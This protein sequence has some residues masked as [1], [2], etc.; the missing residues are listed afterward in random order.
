M[1]RSEAIKYKEEFKGQ[2]ELL[3]LL[4]VKNTKK[5]RNEGNS[6]TNKKS[7]Y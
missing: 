5:R 3:E 4:V 7:G 2:K 6:S 1:S